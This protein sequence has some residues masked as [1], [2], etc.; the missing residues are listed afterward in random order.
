[1]WEFMV[2]PEREIEFVRF[3]GSDGEWY[4][5]FRCSPDFVDTILLKDEKREDFTI[6]TS[7]IRNTLLG[8]RINE[9]KQHFLN[10][11]GNF[12]CIIIYSF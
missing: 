4:Q 2:K 10:I 5:F 7:K 3:N 9:K 1:M 8:K 12:L 11:N 6:N